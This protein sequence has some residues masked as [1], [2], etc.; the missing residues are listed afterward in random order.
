MKIT[1]TSQEES[2]DIDEM[3]NSSPCATFYL[4]LEECLAENNR[5]FKLC[6]LQVKALKECNL[7]YVNNKK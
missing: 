5:N 2:K 7:N 1:P 4:K 6:Q 3:I